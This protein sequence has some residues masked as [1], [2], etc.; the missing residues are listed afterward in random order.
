[1]GRTEHTKHLLA[2]S[3]R[4]LLEE[5]P[6][7][8]ITVA[9][10]ARNCGVSRHTFYYHFKDKQDLVLWI[11]L[12]TRAQAIKVVNVDTVEGNCRRLLTLMKKDALLY[13]QVRHDIDE[14][15][16]HESYYQ[17]NY[18][19]F[20]NLFRSY[21]GERK[22]DPA[23]RDFVAAYFTHAISEIFLD[24]LEGKIEMMPDQVMDLV[25]VIWEKGL[26]G[27]LDHLSTLA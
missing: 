4:Q 26:Y 5:K 21:L 19:C 9:D 24:S 13:T 3:L 6:F 20:L 8:S 16:F 18:H 27:A 25:L 2:D 12:D 14:R 10:I 23:V 1:M 11:Y 15:G 7:S 22:L 17:A